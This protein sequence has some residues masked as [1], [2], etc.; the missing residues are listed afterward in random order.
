MANFKQGTALIPNIL[1]Q[2][3]A[4][5]ELIEL[6]EPV[7][8][9]K[10]EREFWVEVLKLQ[11]K[12]GFKVDP[13]AVK[14][15]SKNIES[16]DLASIEQR[17]LVTKHDVKARIEE[18]NSLAGYELIH[19][20]LTSRDLTDNVELIQIKL[21]LEFIQLKIY[22]LLNLL[23]EKI[24]ESKSLYMVGRTHNVPAQVTTMGKK[25]ATFA[26]ELLISYQYLMHEIA[27]LHFR[28]IKGAI[29]TKQDLLKIFDLDE[30]DKIE[31]ELAHI[32]GFDKVF[33]SVG[34]IY[35]RSQDFS[36]ISR[37]ILICSGINSFA[38]SIRLMS[39]LGLVKEHFL[40]DQTG[41]SAMPHKINPR[42]SERI[43]GLMM[44]L[45][46]YSSIASELSGAQWNEGD[47][48][49]SVVRRVI[50]PDS[51]F[52]ADGIINSIFNI[53]QNL[54][55]NKITI[56]NELEN[57]VSF[58]ASSEILMKLVKRG[59]GR[60]KAHNQIKKIALLSNGNQE[61]FTQDI[62]KIFKNFINREEVYKTLKDYRTL[63][64]SSEIDCE[65]VIKQ[66]KNLEIV[67]H[68]MVEF[69]MRF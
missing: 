25:L 35:P 52:A 68:K 37:L 19:I 7:N 60:E 30:I 48:S 36:Y 24:K 2:R 45:R 17:E 31:D 51:I 44:L 49:C 66:I 13:N 67:N 55:I 38:T 61:K 39:G 8:R 58:I 69:E 26:Q 47:V 42:T 56:E 63:S 10:M 29:G 50:V 18:F 14:S 65:T 22:N 64:G 20:G 57:H 5:Q 43:S 12:Y 54:E 6:F 1:A 3:Y 59:V 34:Q 21:S 9:V 33:S 32:Y 53:L 11:I 27:N 15:Y 4:S 62:L 23:A 46:G 40:S 16:V 41:S 28:G